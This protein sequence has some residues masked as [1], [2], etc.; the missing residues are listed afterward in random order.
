MPSEPTS[1]P[2]NDGVILE[3]ALPNSGDND[4]GQYPALPDEGNN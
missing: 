1:G 2:Y 4:P 3:P